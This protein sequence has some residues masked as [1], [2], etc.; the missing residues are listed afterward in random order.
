MMISKICLELEAIAVI[1]DNFEGLE[2]KAAAFA[3]GI[4]KDGNFVYRTKL[5]ACKLKLVML[6]T[7]EAIRERSKLL[8]KQSRR[9]LT[10]K[11]AREFK[12]A[13][14]FKTNYKRAAFCRATA[15]GFINDEE[16][17]N[18]TNYNSLYGWQ[19]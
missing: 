13:S 1:F 3:G 16:F 5:D 9:P 12:T 15:K 4:I 18:Y 14:N 6:P 11:N 8:L 7:A 10:S 17:D 2:L 19:V